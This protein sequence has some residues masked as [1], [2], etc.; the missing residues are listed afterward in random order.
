MADIAFAEN[1]FSEENSSRVLFAKAC[2]KIS[3]EETISS[4]RLR[5]TDKAT[6]QA[7][8]ALDEIKNLDKE[9]SSHDKNVIIYDI[10]DN[11]VED[12]G[13]QT[14]KQDNNRICVEVTG[15]VTPENIALAVKS[16]KENTPNSSLEEDKPS[17]EDNKEIS[18]TSDIASSS[19]EE[20]VKEDTPEEIIQTSTSASLVSG[21]AK[22]LY[23]APLEFYN[24][25][26]STSFA[27][28]L[29]KVFENNPY[30]DITQNENEADYII[31]SKV[32]RAKVDNINSQTNRMQMVLMVEAQYVDEKTSSTE[33]QNQFILFSKNDDEQKVAS[34]LMQ[35]LLTKAAKVILKKVEK[36][37]QITQKQSQNEA[38]GMIT[39]K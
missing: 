28:I 7:V 18:E 4:I 2:E 8:Q 39:P 12:L 9:F 5:A 20:F 10:V 1:D 33:H 25:T 35:K 27:Q 32:L 15:F 3:K 30:F 13:V 29:L 34:K 11:Y 37:A 31:N 22:K 24:N 16:F 14:T 36:N 19:E 26:K 38:S 17:F 21:K 6:F 23:V